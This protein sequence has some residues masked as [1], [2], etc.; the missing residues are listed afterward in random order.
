MHSMSHMEQRSPSVYAE[1]PEYPGFLLVKPEIGF[2]LLEMMIVV[3]IGLTATAIGVM[4]LQPMLKQGRATD[5]ARSTAERDASAELEQWCNR[6]SADPSAGQAPVTPIKHLVVIFDENQSF[7]HYFGTYPNATNP[8]GQ[9]RF[10]AR[11]GTP[12]VN[13]LTPALLQHN[14]NLFN[15][16]RLDRSV[17]T[18]WSRRPRMP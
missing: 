9:P 2:S 4:S 16:K 17:P 1:M 15:P 13:G 6:A 18:R 10:E 5:G 14:P 8:P 11:A 7:D 3:L 12:A